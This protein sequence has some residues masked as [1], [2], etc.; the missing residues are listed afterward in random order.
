[1]YILFCHT[2]LRDSVPKSRQIHAFRVSVLSI[3]G[4]VLEVKEDNKCLRK[5]RVNAGN[6]LSSNGE[7]RI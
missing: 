3:P 5:A 2:A 1:M 7:V 6:K 4:L